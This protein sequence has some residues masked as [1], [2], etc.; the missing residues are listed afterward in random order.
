MNNQKDT[1]KTELNVYEQNNVS[2]VKPFN[3][4]YISE[5]T[6]KKTEKLVTALYMVSDC[7]E[8]DNALKNQIRLLGVELLSDTYKFSLISPVDKLSHISKT[9][10]HINEIL[11]LIEISY[12]V[13]FISEMNTLILKR[14]FNYLISD[15]KSHQDRDKH[16]TFKIDEDMFN[17]PVEENHIA[18]EGYNQKDNQKD[19]RTEYNNMS[20]INKVSPLSNLNIRKSPLSPKRLIN[21]RERRDKIIS[22]IKMLS[23]KLGQED[24][25]IKDIST[26]YKDCSEKTIQR[27]LNYLVANNTLKKTGAKRWSK[28]G[29]IDK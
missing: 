29:V 12:S 21:K 26:S 11:S 4:K 3:N 13:G 19:K 27:E 1:K 25:S 2:D 28:Y 5:N 10:N 7:M 16:Y 6:N 17:L 15:L 24:I 8:N 14:E 9:L 23:I 22:I 20:F 18:I